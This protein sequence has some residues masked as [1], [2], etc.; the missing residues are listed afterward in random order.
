MELEALLSGLQAFLDAAGLK[1]RK[2][3]VTLRVAPITVF[4]LTDRL[5]L[6]QSVNREL[7]RS[8]NGD[9]WARLEWYERYFKISGFHAGR[10]TNAYQAV[11]DLISS[12]C[13][14]LMKNHETD[15]TKI[16]NR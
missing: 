5:N 11:S 8:A 12:E 16:G 6:C 3:L 10:N 15:Y 2:K 1:D 7:P 13:R 4:W 9:M 14:K